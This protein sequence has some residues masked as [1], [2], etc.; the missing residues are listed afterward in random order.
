MLYNK[1]KVLLRTDPDVKT[2]VDGIE[3][4]K[5]YFVYSYIIGKP[6]KKYEVVYDVAPREVTATISDNI[7]YVYR[8]YKGRRGSC[9][10][11]YGR[12]IYYA[13]TLEEAIDAYEKLVTKQNR[14][15]N[16]ER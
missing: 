16:I 14:L 12:Q 10:G 3:N 4:G 2:P 6:K 7:L 1:H 13:D 8:S 5:T 11:A 15:Y 9:F